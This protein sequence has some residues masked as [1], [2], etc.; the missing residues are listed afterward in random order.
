[1]S[2]RWFSFVLLPLLLAGCTTNQIT[3]LTPRIAHRNADGLYRVEVRWDSTQR[4]IRPDSFKP[5]VVV[6]PE[7][8]PL[9]LTPLT[10]NRWEGLVPAPAGQ[11]FVTYHFKFNY[12]YN[13]IP[14]PR[15]DSRLSQTYQLEIADH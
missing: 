6:G 1:M 14:M 9:Q 8:Y 5:Q 11:R 2:N 12:L 3:N 10:Q 13:S 7:F 4:S 15:A